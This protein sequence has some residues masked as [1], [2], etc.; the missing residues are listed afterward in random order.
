MHDGD[1]G[2]GRATVV[3]V[4]N[5]EGIRTAFVHDGRQGRFTADKR[6]TAPFVREFRPLRGTQAV[7]GNFRREAGD[8]S[9]HIGACNR[10]RGILRDGDR[11]GSGAVF[12]IG[13]CHRVGT[14]GC[15][16][17]TGAVGIIAPLVIIPRRA[18]FYFH[19]G[20]GRRRVAVD[21]IVRR[22]GGGQ[23]VRFFQ[24]N[25]GLRA[26]A[27]GVRDRHRVSSRPEIRS[28]RPCW[29]I[30]PNV[31]KRRIAA[32]GRGLNRT[33]VTTVA[34]RIH[35]IQIDCGFRGIFLDRHRGCRRAAV[36]RI[37]YREG[38]GTA[39]VDYRFERRFA[40]DERGAAP[41]VGKVRPLRG[42]QAVDGDFRIR[43]IDRAGRGGGGHG[44]G[45]ILRDGDGGR[46][47]TIIIVCDRHGIGSAGAEGR[48]LLIRIITP[49][50]GIVGRAAAHIQRRVGGRIIAINLDVGRDGRHERIGFFQR[51]RGDFRAAV[52]IGN[53]D[54][55]GSRRQIVSVRA[56]GAVVPLIGKRRRTAASGHLNRA[57]VAAI[58][59]WIGKIHRQHR[60]IGVFLDG[61]GSGC[62]AAVIRI[63]DGKRVGSAGIDH[64]FE[65]GF[66]ADERGAAPFVGEIGSLRRAQAV[67]GNFRRCASDRAGRGGGGHGRGGVLRDGHRSR[68]GTVIVVGDRDGV[69]SAGG[70]G[71]I[72]LVG[73]VAP[74]ERII[75]RAAAHVQ[76]GIGGR[77]DTINL[78]VGR[79]CRH[80]RIGFFERDRR[81]VRAAIG[82]G[83]RHSISSGTEIVSVRTRWAVVPLISKGGRTAGCGSLYGAVVAAVA[84]RI[85]EIDRQDRLGGVFRDGD[86]GGCSATVV[87]VGDGEGIGSALVDH[88]FEGGFAADEGRAAPLIAKIG[89]LRRPRTVDGHLRVR[90][91][92]DAVECGCGHGRRGILR[93]GD[94]GSSRAVI[95]IRDRYGVG[96]PGSKH[97]ILLVGIVA[98]L[99]S[100]IRRAAADVHR[101]AGGSIVAINRHI[102]GDRDDQRIGRREGNCFRFGTALA[103]CD[104]YGVGSWAQI[105]SVRAG[106]A[107]FPFVSKRIGAP[108]GGGLDGSVIDA[109]A[110]RI[111]RRHGQVDGNF[112]QVHIAAHRAGT[113]ARRFNRDQVV[114]SGLFDGDDRRRATERFCDGVTRRVVL[115]RPGSRTGEGD[116][117]IYRDKI[118]RAKNTA[119][120]KHCRWARLYFYGGRG[121][122]G[123]AAVV[124]DRYGVFRN[125]WRIDGDRRG[126]LAAAPQIGIRR[127]AVLHFW[128]E[129]NRAVSAEVNVLHFHFQRIQV[130]DVERHFLQFATA[131]IF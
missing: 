19:G 130:L 4:R 119:A 109:V 12:A 26:A 38:V 77:V 101:G 75:R 107:V 41:F 55:V 74:L 37:G 20:I 111:L 122:C 23:R 118:V 22:D 68:G 32:G 82:V 88:R 15:E 14:A 24:R 49:Y 50:E 72:L 87:V 85:G 117:E 35:R 54:C 104:R 1:A 51:N 44:R 52:C 112:L 8:L 57:V 34:C 76:R 99:E 3:A 98:P 79:D 84:G 92:Q 120:A 67:D 97:R 31:R 27:V 46:S 25:A 48:I 114:R 71:R 106:R 59:G 89:S 110:G 73:I 58:T 29:A 21:R 125:P 129:R 123:G 105:V 93:Y 62:R 100:I 124:G 60:I 103:V 7:D 11:G 81:H 61:H 13:D 5:G 17:R 115:Q 102:F 95:V 80:E 70:K 39:L 65:G 78:H 56:G 18:A 91:I 94:G 40:A 9:D 126:G 116:G 86:R 45:G 131:G 128:A 96:S 69:G 28:V 66:A 63:R 30:C 127:N 47:G 83:D 64:R 6:G 121:S 53:R 43:T 33:V 2:C 16:A 108:G 36:I 10:R 90:A 42:A 113:S